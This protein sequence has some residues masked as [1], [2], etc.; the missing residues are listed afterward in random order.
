MDHVFKLKWLI[1][2]L[3]AHGYSISYKVVQRFKKRCSPEL[4]F[5]TTSRRN[6]RRFIRP[7]LCSN[8]DHNIVTDGKG[9]FHGM[10]I[11]SMTTGTNV[12]ADVKLIPTNTAVKP[13]P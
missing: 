10:G 11:I 13:K 7:I 8:I 12:A 6:T 1:D 4:Y 5:R 9:M 3:S 2:E